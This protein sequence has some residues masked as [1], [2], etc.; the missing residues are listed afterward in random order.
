MN[1]ERENILQEACFVPDFHP[2][3]F[4]EKPLVLYY[5]HLRKLR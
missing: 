4:W 2:H 5:G 1:S 3:G